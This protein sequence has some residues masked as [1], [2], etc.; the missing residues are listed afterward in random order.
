MAGHIEKRRVKSGVRYRV[1]VGMGH[2]RGS[3]RVSRTVRT[4]RE[5]EAL[6]NE[7]LQAAATGFIP[8]VD[9]TVG[10]LL[11]RWLAE[12]VAVKTAAKT[13]YDYRSI[14]R[15]HL[16]PELGSLR[17]I[18]LRPATL[19]DLWRKQ[20]Q[21]IELED[22]SKKPG[23]SASVIRHNY[24][25]LHAALA[26][27]VGMELLAR[28]VADVASAKPPRTQ[29]RKMRTLT[30]AQML[31]LIEAVKG[32]PMEL[33]VI[34]AVATGAR[35]GEVLALRWGDV[36]LVKDGDTW[37]GH[38][39]ISAALDATPGPRTLK[40]TKTNRQR[41]VA[42]PPFAVEH[43]RQLRAERLRQPDEPIC[44]VIPAW[45][46]SKA[47][48]ELSA[49]LG[50]GGLRLHDIRHSYATMLLEQGTEITQ[51]QEA[52]GH[53]TPVTTLHVYSHVTEAMRE[54]HVETLNRAFAVEAERP[55]SDQNAEVRP[56]AKTEAH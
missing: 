47:W 28:N 37:R 22:G 27:G 55:G 14:V 52:L 2:G 10:E 24:V 8:P 26:W 46:L 34:L 43:L 9:L 32:T 50:L 17:T 41:I 49:R 51:V 40:A 4:K 18:D 12:H 33:P 7:L 25:C 30:A 44:P 16:M 6:L 42:L 23:L 19:S 35:R 39:T 45:A 29:A 20:R 5:A 11:T 13:A 3:R 15:A 36:T 56:I 53:T 31:G 48:R 21:E 1:V 54:R 38:V